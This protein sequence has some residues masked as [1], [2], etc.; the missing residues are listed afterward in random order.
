M[1]E[2]KNTEQIKYAI[3]TAIYKGERYVSIPLELLPNSEN[4]K[5]ILTLSEFGTND[6]HIFKLP[7]SKINFI[8]LM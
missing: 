1:E 4:I 8:I 5:L 6:Q 2:N 7:I 3:I